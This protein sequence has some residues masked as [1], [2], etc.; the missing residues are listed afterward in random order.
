MENIDGKIPDTS[1]FI[2]TQDFNRLTK[3]NFNSRMAESSK[4]LAT[5]KS[6][7]CT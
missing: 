7:D 4:N 5:K 2:L 1:K 3:M 6:R